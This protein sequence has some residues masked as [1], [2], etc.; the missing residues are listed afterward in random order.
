MVERA[1]D[2]LRAGAGSKWYRPALFTLQ[3]DL[4]LLPRLLPLPRHRPECSHPE[5]QTTE[6]HP[7]AVH[8]LPAPESHQVYPFR[9]RHPSGSEGW[10][11]LVPTGPWLP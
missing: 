8:L 5:G 6:G 4:R 1:Q 10:L 3:T 9:A 7:Q 2:G 11:H